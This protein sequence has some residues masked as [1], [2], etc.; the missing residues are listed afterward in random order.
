MAGMK[1]K[2][3]DLFP[4]TSKVPSRYKE[5]TKN[6]V[7]IETDEGAKEITIDDVIDFHAMGRQLSGG[8]IEIG[9]F[10]GDLEEVDEIAEKCLE[11]FKRIN[12]ETLK[13]KAKERG[14]RPKF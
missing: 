13:E 10:S 11:I 2:V 12:K 6:K 8:S 14:L 5:I 4:N 3:Y 1:P 9:E 7:V